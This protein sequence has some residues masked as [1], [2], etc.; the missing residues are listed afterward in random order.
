MYFVD[1]C[2]LG[3]VAGLAQLSLNLK[4]ICDLCY[5]CCILVHKDTG[6]YSV[7]QV[8]IMLIS[9]TMDKADRYHAIHIPFYKIDL[10]T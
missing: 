4:L 5:Y 7:S 8:F 9:A 10:I 2:Q 1:P 3:L 6:S